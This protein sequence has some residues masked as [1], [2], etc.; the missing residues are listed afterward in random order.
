MFVD[1]NPEKLIELISDDNLCVETEE[2]AFNAVMT[3]LDHDSIARSRNFDR[4]LE[5]VRLPLLSPYFLHDCVE[6]HAAIQESD[7]CQLLVQEAKTYHLLTDR[8]TELRSPRTR[9]RKASCKY[10]TA[11]NL[12]KENEWDEV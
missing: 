8:R 3:W 10:L 7:K 4:V 9:P 2:L 11:I 12:Y 1:L 6:K 5:N